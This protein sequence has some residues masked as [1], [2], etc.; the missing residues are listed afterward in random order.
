MTEPSDG[1]ESL[2][3]AEQ[4]LSEHLGLLRDDP[5]VPSGPLVTQVMT[6]ARWQ[7]A[8]SRPLFA[9]GALAQAIKEGIGLLFAPVERR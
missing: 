5:P 3:P 6:T 4:A 8:L 2:S 1:D 7:R 9:I